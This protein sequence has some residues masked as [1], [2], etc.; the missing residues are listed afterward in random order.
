MKVVTGVVTAVALGLGTSGSVWADDSTAVE[1]LKAQLAAFQKQTAEQMAAMQ[2]KIDQMSSAASASSKGPSSTPPE[3]SPLS[4]RIAGADVTLYG[5]V[6]V[7]GDSTNDGRDHLN[8]FSSNQSYL[9]VRGGKELGSGGLKAIFQIETLVD[10]SGTPTDSSS[11]GSRNSFIGLQGDWGKLMIGKYDT[12][13]KRATAMM[14]PLSGS[15]GDYNSVMGNTAGESR[16]EFDFRM[17]HSIFYDSPVWHGF[18]VYAL[19]SP[20]QKLN[21]LPDASNYAFPQGESVCSGSTPGSSGSTPNGNVCN[22]GAFKTATSIA[23]NYQAGPWFS[24]VSYERHNSVDR[25][26][27][28]FGIVADES[29]AKVGLSYHFDGNQ[30]SGIYE[31]F[32][33]GGTIAPNF[34]ERTRDGYYVSDVQDLGHQTDFMFAWAHAG[35]TPGSPHFGDMD[36]RVNMTS[37]G[38]KYHYDAQTALYVVA[39][40]L[41][42]GAGA[43]YSLGAGGHG[44]PVASP[45]SDTGGNFPGQRLDAIS[46]G[47]QYAF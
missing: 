44:I 43:H 25:T 3:Q 45:R 22:D 15:V 41:T 11:L 14:D 30:L 1:A 39:A 16:P 18:S 37:L 5:F 31:K 8:Q 35:Q 33:R 36:D 28:H 2:N 7:S 12:P 38:L 29:A 27:D 20:G 47:L 6:D 32:F 17:P 26:S 40:L 10:V 23:L 24:V 4:T 42:E 19:V 9:G 21:N 46:V 13:Y 34:N